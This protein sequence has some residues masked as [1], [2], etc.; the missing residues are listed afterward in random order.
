VRA[1]EQASEGE[2][3]RGREG[4][5][6]RESKRASEQAS[7][8]A[9]E[10]EIARALA[11]QCPCLCVQHKHRK[12]HRHT[13]LTTI[14]FC[15]SGDHPPLCFACVRVWAGAVSMASQGGLTAPPHQLPHPLLRKHEN[16]R[17]PTPRK[18]SCAQ[19]LLLYYYCLRLLPS[20]TL[21]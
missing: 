5:S 13:Y 17:A 8:R 19:L 18:Q 2:M 9:S 6:E 1:N 20:R 16:A 10:R 21:N 7:K 15:P 11:N 3:E 4:E 12:R 14:S